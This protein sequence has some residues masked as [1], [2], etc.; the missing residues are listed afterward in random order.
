MSIELRILKLRWSFLWVVVRSECE[1]EQTVDTDETET[2]TQETNAQEVATD[3]YNL[4]N[5]SLV[6]DR[7]KHE[8][9]KPTR[10]GHVDIISYA[11]EVT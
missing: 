2:Q 4:R 8:I 6:R 5:Y 11:L 3:A 7:K 1:H 10:L 9:K